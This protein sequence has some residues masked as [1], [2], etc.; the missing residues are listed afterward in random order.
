MPQ[1]QPVTRRKVTNRIAINKHQNAF[2]MGYVSTIAN[3]RRPEKSLADMT[4]MELVNDNTPRPRPPL[5]RYGTQPANTITGRGGYRWNGVRGELFMMNVGGVGKIYTRVDGGAYTLIGG[6]YSVANWAGFRQA[7]SRV[8]I[9]DSATALS[10]L[11]LATMTI[12]NYTSLSTPAAPSGTP[13]AGLTSGTKPYNYYYKVTANNAVG[14]SAASAAS[15]A[16]NVNTIRDLWTSTNNVVLTWSAVAGA[17]S[18]TIYGGDAPT[19][20]YEIITLQNL[21]T[22]SYTD[23]GSQTLNPYKT[24]PASDSTIG[25]IFTWMYVDISN[26]QVFGITSTNQL[27]YSAPGTGDFSALNGGGYTTIDP[28]G[29]TSLNFLDGFHTGKGD[30]VITTSSR[31]AAGKGKL[32]HVTFDSTTYGSQVIFFPNVQEAEG[33]SATY[34]PRATVKADNNLFYPSGDSFKTTGTSMNI[35]NILTTNSIAQDI[36]PDVNQISMANLYK[37]S[38][39]EYQDRIYF[40][41]PVNSTENSEIWYID[42]SRKNAWVLRWPVAAK[43]IWL[44]EDNNGTSH[45]CVLVNNVILE[46]TR[47]GGTTTTDDGVAFR[48]RCAFSSLVWDEDGV[49]L[50]NI[51]NLYVKLLEPQGN[52]VV[53]TFG[54]SQRGSTTDTGSDSYSVEVSY[55]GIGQWD[56]SGNYQYGDDPGAVDQFAQSVAVLHVRPKGL[57]NQLDWEIIT[58]QANCD[59]FL[60]SVNTRGEANTDL[61]YKGGG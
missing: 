20:L 32:H 61:V 12:V 60:S 27:Y 37:A 5:V 59:Y 30:P 29:A 3:S 41:L 10:Y 46:F 44:Y 47:A 18:Y 31:G 54:L 58:E 40:A 34:A 56:Y 52:I 17:T 8:Y 49:S 53:N 48:T 51:H 57:L 15:A 28:G 33:Q 7:N 4:N 19:N 36:I 22:L 26:A 14:E 21:S 6:S 2:P 16:V 1:Y 13:T 50:G 24:A 43:D 39:V 42:L 45:L 35:V 55:T 25:P 23:D 9:Y 38:G 11:D